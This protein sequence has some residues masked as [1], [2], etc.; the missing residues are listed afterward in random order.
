MNFLRKGQQHQTNTENKKKGKRMI[1]SRIFLMIANQS[2]ARGVS[3]DS[4]KKTIDY[5]GKTPTKANFGVGLNS[6]SNCT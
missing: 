4:C 5:R 1:L 2:K 6:D 3:E